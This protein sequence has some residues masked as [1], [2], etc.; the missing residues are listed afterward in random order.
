MA[1][2]RAFSSK[3]GDRSSVCGFVGARFPLQSVQTFFPAFASVPDGSRTSKPGV[4]H[5]PVA[6]VVGHVVDKLLGDDLADVESPVVVP[7]FGRR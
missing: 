1:Y 2:R 7:P 5:V 4:W 3:S 6:I